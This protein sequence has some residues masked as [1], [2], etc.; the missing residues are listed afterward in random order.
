MATTK[1]HLNK[2]TLE[3]MMSHPDSEYNVSIWEQRVKRYAEMGGQFY[4]AD[5]DPNCGYNMFY[6]QYTVNGVLMLSRFNAYHSMLS[7]GGFCMVNI[8]DDGFVVKN[9]FSVDGQT[10]YAKGDSLGM[11]FFRNALTP[12]GI[13]VSKDF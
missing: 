5:K 11:S 13:A 1:I 7:G 10:G 8:N 12:K 9:L 2:L 4:I 6:V 3:Q